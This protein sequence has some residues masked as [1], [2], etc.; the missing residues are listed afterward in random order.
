MRWLAF[1]ALLSSLLG[2]HDE[3]DNCE[4]PELCYSM[5]LGPGTGT[6]DPET[7]DELAQMALQTFTTGGLVCGPQTIAMDTASAI[8]TA[9]YTIEA[10]LTKNGP[11]DGS[12]TL[13]GNCGEFGADCEYSYDVT[14]TETPCG[15]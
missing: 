1:V 4:L 8:C 9:D 13:D 11:L 14:F 3:T 10:D 15:S 5:T 6:C 7:A 12:L 2:C